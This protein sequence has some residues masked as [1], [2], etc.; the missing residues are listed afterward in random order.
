[1]YLECFLTIESLKK[2]NKNSLGKSDQMNKIISSKDFFIE[3]FQNEE[4]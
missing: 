3:V 1:M 4:N 2:S